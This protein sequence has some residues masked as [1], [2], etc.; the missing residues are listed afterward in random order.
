MNVPKTPTGSP[1]LWALSADSGGALRARARRLRDRL[2]ATAEWHPADIAAA[3]ART[4]AATARRA[5][6][7]AEDRA[8]L[9]ERLDAL[10]D[11]R[12]MPG[13][14]E[15]PGPGAAGF[16]GAAFVFPGQ[17]AQWPG[18]AAELLDS[19]PVFRRSV[20]ACAQALEPFLD[21]SLMDVLRALGGTVPLDR[22]DI[23]QPALFAVGVSLAALWSAHGVEPAAVLGHSCGEISAAAVS[24]AL[25]L[26]DSARV[27]ARWSQAQ[28]TLTGRGDMVSVLAST[29]ELRPHLASFD[30]HLVIAA[31]NGP[32]SVIV[33]GDADAAAELVERLTAASVHAR[34]IAVGLA[35]HSP[36][37]D[38]VVPRLHAD[39]APVRPLPAR[40]PY[41]SGLTGD[42]IA[43]PVLDAAYWAR[44]LRNTVRFDRATTALLRDGHSVLLEI[45][46]HPVLTAALRESADTCG[47]PARVT[48]TLRRGRGTGRSSSPRWGS[49]MCTAPPR[50]GKRPSP[51][52]APAPWSRPAARRAATPRT[53]FPGTATAVCPR[54]RAARTRWR[55]PG[56]RWRTLRTRWRAPG[57]RPCPPGERRTGRSARS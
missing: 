21:W 38:A 19:A 3:L 12:G 32:R 16:H 54:W 44:N 15:G 24:G 45:G 26:D 5:A 46:P 14:A 48:A 2:S 8:G 43:E 57:T 9:L 1:V 6:L 25:S 53:A 50:T 11:G 33:S 28:A 40:L 31:V 10:A 47:A 37:I 41:Y 23:A 55:T 30:G 34:R 17:G 39:L 27:V 35:A 56:I 4:P 36:H 51:G 42:L 29:T 7:V 52:P 13:L 49:C 22:A 18:M 20:D